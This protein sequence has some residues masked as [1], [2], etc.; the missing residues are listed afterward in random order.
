MRLL[1]AARPHRRTLLVLGA[2]ILIAAAVRMPFWLSSTYAYGH[3]D[4]IIWEVWSRAIHQH[5]F[6]N[7]LRTADSNNIGYHYVLWPTSV[8]YG[9]I[10]PDYE[11]WTAPIRILIKVPPFLCDLALAALLFVAARRLLPFDASPLRRDVLPALAAGAFVLAP[12][13]IYDSMWWSQIDSVI[14]VTMVGAVLLLARGHAGWAWALWTIGFLFKP[15]PLVIVPPLAA[16]TYWTLGAGATLRGAAAA[17]ATALAALAPFLLHGDARLI[18]ETYDRM[19]EQ[20][21]LDLS[22]GAWNGWSILDARGDPHP[23]STAL[24]LAGLR[25]S[26]ATASLALCSVATLVVLT[27]LRQRLDL[28]GLLAACAMMVFAFYMLPTSTHERY[29][30]AAFALAAPLLVRTPLLAP[31]Y[32]VLSATFFLNLLAINP[33][34]DDQFWRWERTDFAVAVAAFHVAIFLGAMLL[35]AQRAAA[36][37]TRLPG[38]S[39]APAAL[40]HEPRMAYGEQEIG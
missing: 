3:G 25:V 22:Q 34:N 35:I 17:A 32:A 13:T 36:G 7:V 37:L 16:Y 29:L 38:I 21:P 6:I 33:P 23:S 2:L 39:V 5:G 8:I 26:Y 12:A 9:W 20:W 4:A 24:S 27:Y 10:S 11:L 19:F 14:T 30:Y 15:Q 1:A 31:G 28:Y 40:P 18:G